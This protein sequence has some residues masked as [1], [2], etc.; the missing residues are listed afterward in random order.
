MK[1]TYLILALGIFIFF[2]CN[3]DDD[4]FKIMPEND[5]IALEGM[6]EAYENALLYNDSLLF[7]SNE[8]TSCDSAT[9][10]YYDNLF[11]QF[12]EMFDTHHQ[13]YSHNN[14]SDDHHHEEGHN[15]R[16]G[17]MMGHDGEE[18]HNEEENHEYEH[19]METFELM[20]HLK[21]MHDEIHPH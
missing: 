21:E 6:D 18:E 2:A 12:D 8:P 10:F 13:N 14:V 11:H 5:L 17:W 15:I 7:C 4:L 19:S 1:A 20:M 3:K 9:M 16:H